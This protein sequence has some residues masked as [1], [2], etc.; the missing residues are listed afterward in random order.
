MIDRFQRLI[1]KLNVR[2]CSKVER[3]YREV[4]AY[5]IPGG[6][7]AGAYTLPFLLILSRF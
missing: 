7:E 5:A 3:I 1:S 2:R 6:S 4:K